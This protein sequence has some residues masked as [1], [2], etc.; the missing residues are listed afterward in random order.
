[1]HA[2]RHWVFLVV[3]PLLTAFSCVTTRD[4][5]VRQGSERQ[6]SI[7]DETFE[8][9]LKRLPRTSLVAPVPC[10]QELRRGYQLRRTDEDG[11]WW[12]TYVTLVR[13]PTEVKILVSNGTGPMEGIHFLHNEIDAA[14]RNSADV[15]LADK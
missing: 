11:F 15:S 10:S 4:F 8:A 3:L 1:M 9:A 7:T 2:I 14:L 13:L 12:D 5:V 6:G